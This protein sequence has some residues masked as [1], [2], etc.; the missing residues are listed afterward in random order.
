LTSDLSLR[1]SAGAIV[2]PICRRDL[3]AGAPTD[4]PERT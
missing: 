1:S 2:S 4:A 3:V